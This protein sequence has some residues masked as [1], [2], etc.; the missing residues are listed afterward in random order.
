LLE[1]IT[2]SSATWQ[3]DNKVFALP[4][5]SHLAEPRDRP[6]TK[7]TDTE[8]QEH[9]VT[10]NVTFPVETLIVEQSG[11]GEKLGGCNLS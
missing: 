4:H 7:C 2:F 11:G 3:Q 6:G 10:W 9:V 5:L 1:T 8:R